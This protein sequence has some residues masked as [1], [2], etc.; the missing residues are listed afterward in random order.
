[1]FT[2]DLKT[3]TTTVTVLKSQSI[4]ATNT[5]TGV[6]TAAYAGNMLLI[7]NIAA[8]TAGTTPTM[9]VKVQDSADNS[10]FADVTGLTLTQV[11]TTDSL[12]TLSIDKRT[13]RRYIRTISTIGGTSSPAFPMSL[14]LTAYKQTT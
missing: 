11:T 9:D 3:E 2:K 13:V 1:M 10:S 14:T 8:A 12:Q 7:A 5:G 4:T 6:D